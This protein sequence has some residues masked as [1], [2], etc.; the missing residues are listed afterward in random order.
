MGAELPHII[1][2]VSS[3]CDDLR[4]FIQRQDTRLRSAVPAELNVAV[5]VYRLAHGQTYLALSK[6]L[7]VPISTCHKICEEVYQVICEQLKPQVIQFP[8]G[9]A[10]DRNI[11]AFEHRK[12][13]P[14][15]VG[16][17]DGSHIPIQMPF[18]R[19]GHLD[20]RNRKG[21]YSI[22]LQGCVDFDCKFISVYVGFPGRAHD[23]R[24]YK[25]SSLCKR[26]NAGELLPNIY[27]EIEGFKVFLTFWVMLL[28]G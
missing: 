10:L 12:R 3:V 17:V 7:G 21:F 27:R 6:S 25:C 28:M 5:A 2:R 14:L 24:V 13:L 23:G 26:I 20:Y 22:I 11:T 4:P 8:Q 9:D 15:C 19:Q 16:A 18:H 1:W